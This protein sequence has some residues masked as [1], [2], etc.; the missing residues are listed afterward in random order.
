[1]TVAAFLLAGVLMGSPALAQYPP[2]AP[3]AEASDTKVVPGQPITVSGTDWQAGSDVTISFL[4]TPLFLGTGTVG[5]EGTFS[6]KV[7][8]PSD[9]SAGAHT[10]RV[11]G[12]D[13]DGVPATVG[14]A[15][16]VVAAAAEEEVDT[17]GLAFTGT[18]I[19]IG[20]L[21]VAGLL[22]AGGL[23]LWAARRRNRTPTN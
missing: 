9:A 13:R 10:L 11:S 1:M 6:A 8:I 21:I 2:A 7:T 23:A 12:D 17:G 18:N 22:I 15:I 16:Q 3:T 14:I 19:S 5:P 20:L 4:S